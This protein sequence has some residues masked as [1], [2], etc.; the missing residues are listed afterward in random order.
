MTKRDLLGHLADAD[1]ADAIEVADAFGLAYSAAAMAL[2]R[3]L[4]Q[5]LVRRYVD[6]ANGAYWYSL[7]AR[8]HDRLS[9]LRNEE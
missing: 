4:R 9:Y 6:D 7:T 5:G 2:L 1:H 8:G 3:L